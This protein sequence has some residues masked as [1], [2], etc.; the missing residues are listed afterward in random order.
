[1]ALRGRPGSF[2]WRYLRFTFAGG[3]LFQN[4]LKALC[5]VAAFR[6]LRG[7]FKAI[8]LGFLVFRQWSIGWDVTIAG[9]AQVSVLAPEIRLKVGNDP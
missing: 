8:R 5:G 4:R 9:F 2:L 3:D 1:M 7:F 6:F